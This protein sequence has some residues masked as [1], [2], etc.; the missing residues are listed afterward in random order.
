MGL[1]LHS[2][3]WDQSKQEG[4]D[5]MKKNAVKNTHISTFQDITIVKT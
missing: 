5:M 1:N 4:I 2:Y 3:V